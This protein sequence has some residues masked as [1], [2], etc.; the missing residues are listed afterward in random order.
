MTC[1]LIVLINLESGRLPPFA[2]GSGS[3]LV[4]SGFHYAFTRLVVEPGT[5]NSLRTSLVSSDSLEREHSLL[6]HQIS[7]ILALPTLS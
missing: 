2:S 5:S 6:D 4:H 1:R 3:F 7:R